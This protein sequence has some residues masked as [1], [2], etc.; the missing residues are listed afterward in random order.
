MRVHVCACVYL[1][2]FMRV[3]LC[4]HLKG[5]KGVWYLSRAAKGGKVVIPNHTFGMLFVCKYVRSC[6]GAYVCA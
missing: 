2:P 4:N 1:A 6:Y 3:N 5:V